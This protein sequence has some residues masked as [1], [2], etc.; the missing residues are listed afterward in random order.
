MA[1]KWHE[2]INRPGA[3]VHA[4]RTSA[5]PIISRADLGT[6]HGAWSPSETSVPSPQV[7]MCAVIIRVWYASFTYSLSNAR[8]IIAREAV[9]GGA[10]D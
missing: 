1:D 3:T 5:D 4:I 7:D 9:T 2:A 8:G 6:F 10:D